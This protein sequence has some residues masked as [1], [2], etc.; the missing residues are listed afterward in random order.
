[1]RLILLALLAAAAMLVSSATASAHT[2]FQKFVRENSG[3]A[4]NCAMCHVHS[5]GP[6]GTGSGQV[7]GLSAIEMLRL[8]RARSAFDPGQEVDS[9]ILNEFGNSIITRIGK[10]K[11]LELRLR[12]DLLA[13]AL[14]D[15][16]DLDGDGISDAREYL[17]GTHPLQSSDGDPWLLF[18]HNLRRYGFHI[19]MIATATVLTLYGLMSLLAGLAQAQR[20]AAARAR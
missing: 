12:P 2:E 6:E 4:I 11:L 18:K 16:I 13:V 1:M 17:D 3:R 7:G 9:P 20:K 8:N 14:G 19:V 15:E 5:D 10:R